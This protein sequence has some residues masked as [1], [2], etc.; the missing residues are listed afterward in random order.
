MAYTLAL[1]AVTQSST[2]PEADPPEVG[3][4]APCCPL[5]PCPHLSPSSQEVTP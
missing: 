1:D 5:L 2:R 4:R 3:L